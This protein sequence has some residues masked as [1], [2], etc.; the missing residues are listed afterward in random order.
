MKRS[1]A[2][3]D[4]RDSEIREL[5]NDLYFARSTVLDLL[6]E[7]IQDIL[8]SYYQVGTVKETYMWLGDVSSD[9]IDVASPLPR[10]SVYEMNDRA[11]C[12]LCGCGPQSLY[13]KGFVLPE[14]LRR[15]L[16]GGGN[17]SQCK[18]LKV[19]SG[20]A[21]DAWDR[22]FHPRGSSERQSLEDALESRRRKENQYLIKN[23]SVN[24]R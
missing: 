5:E 8:K 9:L 11:I 6:P 10:E 14:G 13:D 2:K 4:S 22:K 3:I 23:L 17:S 18:V 24:K 12:P 1:Y 21:N 20:L 7:S 15:H 16:E 19:V